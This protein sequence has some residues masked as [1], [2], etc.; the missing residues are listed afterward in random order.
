M[1]VEIGAGSFI[2]TGVHLLGKTKIGEEC[3][4]GAFTIMEVTIVGDGSNIRSN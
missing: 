1:N 2:G 4:V 3:F